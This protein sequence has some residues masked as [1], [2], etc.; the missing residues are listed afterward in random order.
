M[1]SKASEDFP[2]PETPLTTVS[3]PCGISQEMFF[4]LWVRAPRMTIESFALSN[5]KTPIGS[6]PAAS[7]SP[8]QGSER[9]WPFFIIRRV[10]RVERSRSQ[11]G[12]NARGE[13]N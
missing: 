13:Q 8:Q 3:L 7:Q 9:N 4:K 2:E 1:V 12:A 10:R 11:R 5:E 6:C